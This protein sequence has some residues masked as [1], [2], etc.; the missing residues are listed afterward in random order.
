VLYVGA[1]YSV[2]MSTEV[3]RLVP[4]SERPLRARVAA[5]IRAELARNDVT[6]VQVAAALGIT[7]QAVSQKLS[8]RRPFSLDDVE[9]IAPM[10]GMAPDELVRGSKNPQPAGPTGAGARPEGFE[11]PTF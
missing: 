2:A 3:T 8:G 6:Q 7:Q 1:V 11:P 10:V 4:I 5:N 9:V